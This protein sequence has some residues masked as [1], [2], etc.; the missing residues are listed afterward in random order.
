MSDLSKHLE[1]QAQLGVFDSEGHFTLNTQ[2]AGSKL[3]SFGS[4][5]PSDFVLLFVDA[6]MKAR[7]KRMRIDVTPTSLALVFEEVKF[8]RPEALREILQLPLE[9][10]FSS[11][12]SRVE[13]DQWRG[14]EPG[15]RMVFTSDDRQSFELGHSSKTELRISLHFG[16]DWRRSF[17]YHLAK[18]RGSLV[19]SRES[20]VIEARCR[21]SEIPILIGTQ[22]VNQ[23]PILPKALYHTVVGQLTEWPSVAEKAL[24]IPSSSWRGAFAL[25]P[26]EIRVIVRQ[27]TICELPNLGMSGYLY[28][29]TL[30]LD[31]SQRALVQDDSFEAMIR[32]LAKVKMRM[33]EELALNVNDIYLEYTLPFLGEL[34]ECANKKM[35]SREATEV[36]VGWMESRV[37]A[38]EFAAQVNHG[39]RGY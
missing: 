24:Q 21:S 39:A 34:T 18:F 28:H 12:V 4:R 9:R 33:L 29:D 5:L 23:R 25:T 11:Q 38:A 15:K 6:G 31:L 2:K 19:L 16:K 22:K 13:I 27:V 10:A 3:K 36:F 14:S 30:Q 32:K 35:L 37:G 26:G 7:P 1:S 17:F 8:D 20:K